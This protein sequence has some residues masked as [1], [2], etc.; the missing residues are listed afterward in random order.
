MAAASVR[1]CSGVVML[2]AGLAGTASSIAQVVDT[3][4]HILTTV[5]DGVYVIRHTG[6]GRRGAFSGSTT[7]VVGDRHTLVIDSGSAP[8]VA[9]LDI[10]VIR[11]WTG[12]P[13][14]Y[15]VNTHWH[16]DH[17]WGNQAYVEAFPTV[18]IVAHPHTIR[19]MAGYLPPFVTGT[20]T[21]PEDMKRALATGIDLD[22]EPL[23]VNRRKEIE[24]ELVWARQRADEFTTLKEQLPTVSVE[25]EL[26]LDLGNRR[27]ELKHLGRGNTAGDLIVWLPKEKIVVAG[28]LLVSPNPFFF[29][30]FPGEWSRTL[31]RILA[32][33]P[34]VVVPGHGA[35]LTGQDGR[36]FVALVR[37]WLATVSSEVRKAVYALG[38]IP[39]DNDGAKRRHLERL[40]EA[41]LKSD[42]IKTLR[43]RVAGGDQAKLQFFDRSLVNIVDAAYREAW[44]D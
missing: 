43:E 39:G 23:S 41:V 31:E 19:S 38:N 11:K 18:S 6:A 25:Q 3:G 2:V 24:G 9:R 15:L 28:D 29:G 32:L 4:E 8:S 14:T 33:N 5:T 7:V 42:E 44:G 37:D 1:W 21:R 22:G 17:T 12:T 34:D 35:V 10:D 20:V 13:V 16:G 26:T 30:G 27:V 40:R 36:A